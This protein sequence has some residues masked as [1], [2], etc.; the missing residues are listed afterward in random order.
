MSVPSGEPY[1]QKPVERP[2]P[3]SSSVAVNDQTEETAEVKEDSQ[4]QPSALSQPQPHQ[5]QT[6]STGLSDN[7]N[8]LSLQEPLQTQAASQSES[9]AAH[10]STANAEQHTAEDPFGEWIL[11]EITWP[12]PRIGGYRRTVKVFTQ[13]ANGPCSLLALANVLILRG[14]IHIPAK[15]EKITYDALATLI[16]DFLVTRPQDSTNSRSRGLTLEAALNILPTTV[17]GLNVNV[18]FDEI[19]SFRATEEGS[20][21]ELALFAMAGVEL[22]H[23]WIADKSSSSGE[24]EALQRVSEEGGVEGGKSVPTY[25]GVQEAIIKGLDEQGQSSSDGELRAPC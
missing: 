18:G 12:D 25:D 24:W 7:L 9:A 22:V 21:D 14:S 16:A 11:K 17:R 10:I 19:T 13:N 3:S 2:A 8:N 4:Q 1:T 15:L 6:P 5:Q 20:S 23:G